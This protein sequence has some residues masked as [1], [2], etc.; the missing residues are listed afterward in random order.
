[1]VIIQSFVNV[2]TTNLNKSTYQKLRKFLFGT[3]STD[4]ENVTCS[5]MNFW[6]LLFGSMGST[7]PD[8]S[9]DPKGGDLGYSWRPGKEMRKKLFELKAKEGDANPGAPFEDYYP[10]GCSWSALIPLFE[11]S[12]IPTMTLLMMTTMMSSRRVAKR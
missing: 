5:D 2:D 3:C 11:P 9:Y 4:S 1:M 12:T 7:D 8:L 10:D 6:L